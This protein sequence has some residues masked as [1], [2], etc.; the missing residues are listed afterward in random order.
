[1]S[2]TLGADYSF[3]RED[4]NRLFC[5]PTSDVIRLIIATN[6]QKLAAFVKSLVAPMRTVAIAA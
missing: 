5:M 6:L 1:M 2:V 3:R 4:F